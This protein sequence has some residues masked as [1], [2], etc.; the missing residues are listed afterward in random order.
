[1]SNY[2][3]W[4]S[5]TWDNEG[6]E[7]HGVELVPARA[8][9]RDLFNALDAAGKDVSDAP[10]GIADEA[11]AVVAC[12]LR[13]GT[14]IHVMS[15]GEYFP[16]F[17]R[18][19]GLSRISDDEMKRVNIEFSSALSEWWRE[20][21]NDPMKVWRRSRTVL[22]L[23]PITWD[24]DPF[25]IQGRAEILA[26]FLEKA[27]ENKAIESAPEAST[28]QEANFAVAQA[29]RNGAIEGLHAGTWSLGSE[30]PGFVRLY[31]GEVRQICSTA[32]E[33]LGSIMIAREHLDTGRVFAA[34]SSMAAPSGWSLMDETAT[35]RFHG[36]P[37]LGPLDDRLHALAKR[38]P[39]L[40]AGEP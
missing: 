21:A 24:A 6:R 39:A 23:L 5:F 19:D 12:C 16:E 10:V 1:V 37:E 25:I 29:Y 17:A 14:Y 32:T 35:V 18:N 20:R 15:G 4:R 11:A 3:R 26:E 40:F 9:W 30:V 8:P 38:C 28:R 22:E 13:Y 2:G 34:V 27:A 36:M 33:V 31:A 7:Q